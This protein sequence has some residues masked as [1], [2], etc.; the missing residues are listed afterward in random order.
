[1]ALTLE[2]IVSVGLGKAANATKKLGC[3]P[4]DLPSE[5]MLPPCRAVPGSRAS[6]GKRCGQGTGLAAKAVAAQ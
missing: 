3:V 1:M 6:A 5:Q 4:R 2:W